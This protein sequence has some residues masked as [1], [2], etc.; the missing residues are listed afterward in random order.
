MEINDGPESTERIRKF[1][2]DGRL[3]TLELSL[4]RV[5][6][7]WRKEERQKEYL[8]QKLE[9]ERENRSHSKK[10]EEAKGKRGLP[11]DVQNSLTKRKERMREKL[12]NK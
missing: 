4:P 5:G 1:S 11:T 12:K 3:I 2:E 7:D 10:A 6:I 8:R 9:R